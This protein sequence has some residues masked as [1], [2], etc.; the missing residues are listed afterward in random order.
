MNRW[1][2][3]TETL[4]NCI[5]RTTNEDELRAFKYIERQMQQMNDYQDHYPEEPRVYSAV[6]Q[7][8]DLL[9]RLAYTLTEIKN[10]IVVDIKDDPKGLS[11]LSNHPLSCGNGLEQYIKE[12]D[13]SAWDYYLDFSATVKIIE[14]A[15]EGLGG[16]RPVYAL[17]SEDRGLP[18]DLAV[19]R[20]ECNLLRREVQFLRREK[21]DREL[22]DKILGDICGRLEHTQYI[23]KILKLREVEEA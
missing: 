8:R 18:M 20:D 3:L 2:S 16:K 7:T 5:K 23:D 15:I 11:K 12:G 13:Y 21:S 14:D 19:L 4:R 17:M 6:E 9:S 10:F 1:E 22:L